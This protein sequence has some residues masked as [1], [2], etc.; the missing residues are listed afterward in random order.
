MTVELTKDSID[1]G[2]VVRDID[3]AL[4]F[5]RDTL[6]FKPAGDDDMPGGMH[7]WRL[8]CGTSM[9]KLVTFERTP[10]GEPARGS[11][12]K[13]FGYRYWTMSVGNLADIVA[14]CEKGG[15]KVAVP[16]TNIRAGVEIAIVEDPDGN[17][18]EFL[19]ATS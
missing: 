17:W 13:G 9:I 5:Y 7:M 8:M 14:A 4:G 16:I 11:I 2:I 1:L 18:V 12:G 19:G 10:Q 3:T 15:Y 6:G